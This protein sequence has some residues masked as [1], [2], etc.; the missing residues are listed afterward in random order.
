MLGISKRLICIDNDGDD[1]LVINRKY[2]C[3]K[4]EY[5]K[6]YFIY[7]KDKPVG[8]F[9]CNLF[10]TIEQIREQRINYLL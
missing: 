4:Y 6:D 5:D 8:L 3:V 2:W 10:K 9:P 7:Y 1:R